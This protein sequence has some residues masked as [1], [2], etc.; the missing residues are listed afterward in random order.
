M[1][2]ENNNHILIEVL[3][4]NGDLKLTKFRKPRAMWQNYDYPDEYV[5][6]DVDIVNV[7][8]L[9]Q[10]NKQLKEELNQKNKI[11]EEIKTIIDNYKNLCNDKG[12]NMNLTVSM[13]EDILTPKGSEDND[14]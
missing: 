13:I 4:N 11:I 1:N 5:F 8:Q 7:F 10:E 9:I 3:N 12:L 6:R 14:I 2:K